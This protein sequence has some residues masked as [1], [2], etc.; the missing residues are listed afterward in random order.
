VKEMIDGNGRTLS[1]FLFARDI[2][3]MNQYDWENTGIISELMLTRAEQIV[4][5]WRELINENLRMAKE[6][7]EYYSSATRLLKGDHGLDYTFM[8]GLKS[9]NGNEPAKM[10]DKP[11]TGC[12]MNKDDIKLLND[13][14]IN[15]KASF[16]EGYY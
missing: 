4:E 16:Y 11:I 1:K 2:S 10:D 15:E 9:R 6:C 5:I 8:M 3:L 7:L 13:A 12:F 14:M